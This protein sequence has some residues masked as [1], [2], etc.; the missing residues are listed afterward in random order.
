[1]TLE[2]AT[3]ATVSKHG[4]HN[5]L[6]HGNRTSGGIDRADMP[7]IPKRN[8]AAFLAELDAE[9]TGYSDEDVDPRS[10]ARTQ[11]AIAPD[12]VAQMHAGMVDGSFPVD[13]ARIIVSSDNKVLDGHHRWAA[14]AQYAESHPG[15][16]IPV[17][18][19]NLSMSDL[20]ARAA[21]FNE[22]QGIAG[23]GIGDG[24]RVRKHGTH[25][26]KTH[27]R[28]GVSSAVAASILERVKANGGLSVDM[29]DG[30]EPTSGFMVAKYRGSGAVLSEAEFFDPVEGP[31]ALSSFLKANR[32]DLAGGDY[33]GVWH[34][35]ADGQ[36]YLDV[37]ENP[38]SRQTAQFRGRVR[39]QISIWDVVNFEE[40]PTGGSG[41]V[42]KGG[43]YAG[44]SEGDQ[45][46]GHLEDVGRGDRRVRAGVVGEDGGVA[47]WFAPG[48]KPVLKHG[49]H[50]QSAHGNWSSGSATVPEGWSQRSREEIRGD[51]AQAPWVTDIED[52]KAREEYVRKM[53]TRDYYDGPNG[54]T[55]I[56]DR[57]AGLI[58]SEVNAQLEALSTLQSIA[59]IP[60]QV[61]RIDNEPF[62]SEGLPA[63]TQ[64]FVV[65]GDTTI[66][67]R[68][69]AVVSG[70]Q[71]ESG[72]MPVFG[73]RPQLYAVTHEYGHAIDQRSA[74]ESASVFSEARLVAQ[75]GMSAYA[76]SGDHPRAPGREAFAEAWTGWVGSQGAS[77]SP[78]VQYYA[79]TYEWTAGSGGL[80][81]SIAKAANMI[82]PDGRVILAD[83]FTD[84]GAIVVESKVR[85][86]VTI[87][88]A[89]GLKPVL[90]HGSHDQSTHGNWASGVPGQYT[91][92]GGSLKQ[93]R[94]RPLN[95][96]SIA[97]GDW[98]A[99]H[100][101][102]RAATARVLGGDHPEVGFAELG[103]GES[104]LAL[105]VGAAVGRVQRRIDSLLESWGL[106][107]KRAG[108]TY[109]AEEAEALRAD[110][111]ARY[112]KPT[113]MDKARAWV[114]G[115]WHG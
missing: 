11:R 7:Q 101:R 6:T 82:E 18:R 61:V 51:L 83:T 20:L 78:F 75:V 12:N 47:V 113:W 26:Q 68:P 31:K 5:Q 23:R 115:V 71:R 10:L 88:F 84:E 43:S 37:A 89:P 39:D 102:E 32:T 52:P 25:D 41:T 103:V 77:T 86:A 107:P 2:F 29:L 9:G 22:E 40:V 4:S 114:R 69:S 59:P 33:L 87:Q 13:G 98:V 44:T 49:S 73:D 85:K 104:N 27:G 16:T 55:V 91:D 28:R 57:G 35:Q 100:E 106:R 110:Y 67:L 79:E 60:N 46:A 8:R 66:N 111:Y 74:S 99:Q 112:G 97:T 14:A 58:P 34:N 76:Q 96:D 92:P 105:G 65:L 50:D 81:A 30:H 72:L 90:K 80:R 17:T 63:S 19:V 95:V 1:V 94:R 38:A 24:P 56:V 42:S 54:M 3:A 108:Y 48:L 64:G 93:P 21:R 53:D 36:V 70:V 62:K 109:T 15:T 45:V